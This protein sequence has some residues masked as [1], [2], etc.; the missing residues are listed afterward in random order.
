MHNIVVFKAELD[1]GLE[2]LVKSNSSVAYTT[3]IIP[4]EEF[5]VSDVVRQHIQAKAS[6]ANATLHYLKTLLV[7]TGWNNNDDYFDTLETWV[8]RHTPEDTPFNYQ[9]ECDQIIGHIIGNYVID[10]EGKVVADDATNDNIPCSFHVITPSVLYKAWEKPEL[11]ERADKLLAEIAEGK[12]FV[13]MECYF[14]GF[15]YVLKSTDGSSRMVA[16]NEQTAFLTKHLR[17]YGGSGKYDGQKVGRV[18]RNICFSGKGLVSNPANPDSVIFAE[19]GKVLGYKSASVLNPETKSVGATK[20]MNEIE[21]QLA[22]AKAEVEQLKAKLH[23]TDTKNVQKQL[24]V[25]KAEVAD[26]AAKLVSANESITKLGDSNRVILTQL[27]ETK[28]ALVAKT[29]EYSKASEELHDIKETQRK[30]ERLAKLKAALKISET[31]GEAVKDAEK[32]SDSLA[33]LSDEQFDSYVAVQAKFTS[34]PLPPKS[35]PAPLPPKSTSKPAPLHGEASEVDANEGAA[36]TDLS[37]A[38]AEKAAAL[39]TVGE[40]SGVKNT[41]LA[42]AKMFGFQEPKSE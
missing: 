32:L 20:N 30:A 42:I 26:L 35:T 33:G 40:Q 11:Q 9:H 18:L 16:R 36:N 38:E 41:R 12:W 34:V 27:E 5:T 21:K 24:D 28:A 13:S 23:E 7:S 6:T 29:E 39:A 3:K 17:C 37:K 31:N 8:A 4:S 25:A 10:D 15:D 2:E 1:A 14:K 22:D 19:A